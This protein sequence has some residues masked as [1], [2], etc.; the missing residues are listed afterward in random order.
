MEG[1]WGLQLLP[2]RSL[3][4]VVLRGQGQQRDLLS[5]A[6]AWAEPHMEASPC[7]P[8]GGQGLRLCH[9][10][11]VRRI[12]KEGGAARPLLR[13][14][15]ASS[16]RQAPK[17]R[18]WTPKG[19]GAGGSAHSS[20]PSP[21]LFCPGSL[22]VRL[23][24]G[25]KLLHPEPGATSRWPPPSACLPQQMQIIFTIMEVRLSSMR[26]SVKGQKKS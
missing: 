1:A 14:Q 3:G 26:R 15:A 5:P 8:E 12:M 11:P 16:P 18:S 6:R 13:K 21:E 20:R 23:G 25:Q 9:P 17:G 10:Q 24:G 19:Q 7:P 4:Q 2:S 22:H